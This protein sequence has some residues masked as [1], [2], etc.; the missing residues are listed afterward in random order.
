MAKATGATYAVHFRRRRDGI[1]DYATRLALL[2]SG[3]PRMVVRKTNRYVCVQF[4][5]FGEKGDKA[6]TSATSK[7]LSKY[8]F[9]GKCNSPSAYL[10]G[11][12]CAKKAQAKGVKEFVRDIGLQTAS[13]GAVVFSALKGAVDAGL[14][15]N[16][17]EEKMPSPARSGG[18]HLNQKKQF[19]DAKNKIMQDVVK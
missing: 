19:D 3:K 10:T 15:A 4:V 18:E 17:G 6:I 1:T 5:E 14:K 13:K 7:A 11:M 12:L 2:K 9:A 8:G 16:F